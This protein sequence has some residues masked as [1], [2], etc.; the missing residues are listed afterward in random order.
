[1]D[2]GSNRVKRYSALKH[3]I[4]I[5]ETVIS[6]IFFAVLYKS[7][8][9]LSLARLVNAISGNFYISLLLYIS[10]LGLSLQLLSF[11]FDFLG[12]YK[13]EHAFGL[14]RQHIIS[15]L[16][17]Y[18][19]KIIIGAVIYMIAVFILYFFLRNSEYFWWLFTAVLYF[20]LS[21]ILAKVFPV[22]IIPLFFKLTR[23][24]DTSL[25]ERLISLGK[26][27]EVQILDVYNI[28]LGEKT[29]KANAAVC[30]LGSTKR[31]LLSDT[32]IES[33]SAQE[34]EVT[35]AHE[36]AHHKHHHFWKL[37]L[38]N[39]VITLLGFAFMGLVLA[40]SV[41]FGQI[42]GIA[43]MRAFPLLAF[44]F[45]AYNF[46]MSPILNYVSRK[47]EFE[48]D[49]EAIILTKAPQVFGSLMRKLSGQNLSDPEP[50]W[51]MKILFYDHPPVKERIKAS[52]EIL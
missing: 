38:L 40:R 26:K 51:I 48:A 33:Y 1:M 9:S 49:R 8:L 28:A 39:L 25:R 19:K 45:V 43:D 23:L 44:V 22:V 21:V 10:V 6:L 35:L 16:K 12:S 4:T 20:F 27:L 17:D 32:L 2:S 30:G 13:L 47:Y 41:A 37:T 11:S 5:A 24:S 15:W 29:K 7:G 31:I 46:L 18:L 14:S 52:E 42:E 3:S 34:I 50:S 36:L